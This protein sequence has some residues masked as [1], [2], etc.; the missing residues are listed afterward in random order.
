MQTITS[1]NKT[2]IKPKPS[3][4]QILPRNRDSKKQKRVATKQTIEQKQTLVETVREKEECLG[5]E[6]S[7]YT[8]RRASYQLK[9]NIVS[10]LNHNETVKEEKQ[11][12]KLTPGQTIFNF[13]Q[14]KSK[15]ESSAKL[16]RKRSVDM[17]EFETT[18][19]KQKPNLAMLRNQ[20]Q[21]PG[22]KWDRGDTAGQVSDSSRAS[23]S[24]LEEV[25]QQQQQLD[26]SAHC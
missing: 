17:P 18:S 25:L 14:N 2:K 16:K 21:P 4:K 15:P 1:Q 19:K 9:I 22:D 24:S 8:N 23:T 11:K 6:Y 10:S 7:Q 5:E 12:N 13:N 3:L 26:E 20:G